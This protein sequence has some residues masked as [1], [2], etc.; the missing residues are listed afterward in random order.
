MNNDEL[1]AARLNEL[2]KRLAELAAELRR[3]L[4]EGA[5]AAKVVQLDQTSVG[6]L[7]RMDAMQQQAMAEATRRQ[8]R[9]RLQQCRA[10]EQAM[11]AGEYG[12]CR[13]CEEE[14]GYKRLFVRP[15]TPFC[16]ACQRAA[17]RR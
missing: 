17:D 7:T 16:I 5:D 1:T 15:E 2:R 3:G 14:I 4:A 8:L 10:A 13:K 9:I 12:Y 11:D 6:R